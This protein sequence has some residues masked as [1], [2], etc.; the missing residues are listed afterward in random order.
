MT[1]A[2]IYQRYSK[3]VYNSIYRIIQHTGEAED[4]LQETFLEAFSN[5]DSF[6]KHP[7]PAAWLKR[8]GMNKAIGLLR[9]N[10]FLLIEDDESFIDYEVETIDELG[11]ELKL[12]QVM[13]A[14]NKLPVGYRTIVQLYLIEDM[15]QEEIATL[16]GIA[17]GTV[18][19]QYSR[20]KKQILKFIQHEQ[21]NG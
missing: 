8:V 13:D 6:M 11:F 2:E 17:H 5:L 16:L 20:A 21:S 4:L 3:E 19:S 12:T 7:S 18:R 10:R 14:I 15:P 1:Y 9:K